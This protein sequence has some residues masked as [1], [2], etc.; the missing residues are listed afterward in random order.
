MN[1][2][3]EEHYELKWS[4]ISEAYISFLSFHGILEMMRPILPQKKLIVTHCISY[5]PGKIEVESD[6][7]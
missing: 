2:I 7:I 1:E 3:H 6:L 5:H 4:F